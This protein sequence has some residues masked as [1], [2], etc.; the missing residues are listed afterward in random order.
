MKELPEHEKRHAPLSFSEVITGTTTASNIG[1]MQDGA[2]FHFKEEL[3]KLKKG[4]LLKMILNQRERKC[5]LGGACRFLLEYRRILFCVSEILGRG[6]QVEGQRINSGQE[7]QSE[8]EKS[9]R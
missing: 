5:V 8:G 2:V 3:R 4:D 9:Q 6:C 7:V 1:Q